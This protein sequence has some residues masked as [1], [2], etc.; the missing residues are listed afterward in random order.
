MKYYYENRE[1]CKERSRIWQK[2]NK[3]RVNAMKRK[4]YAENPEL[5]RKKQ[6]EYRERKKGDNLIAEQEKSV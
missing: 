1:K 5:Y 6:R 2:N 3:E 4:R